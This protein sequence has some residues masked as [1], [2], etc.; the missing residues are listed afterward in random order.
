MHPQPTEPAAYPF[1]VVQSS[2]GTENFEINAAN[3]NMDQV[4]VRSWVALETAKKVLAE[5]GQDFDALKKA[6]LRKDF[7]PVPL[8]GTTASFSLHAAV[9]R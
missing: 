9:A 1:S 5:S 8:E 2:W 6:A 4:M 3:K 7:R